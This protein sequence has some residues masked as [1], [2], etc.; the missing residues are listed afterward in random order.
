MRQE[1]T[2][3]PRTSGGPLTESCRP[4]LRT[5]V[6]TPQARG[7]LKDA[8]PV[9]S[10]LPIPRS[11]STEPTSLPLTGTHLSTHCPG[12][13]PPRAVVCMVYFPGDGFSFDSVLAHS[14]MAPILARGQL[15]MTEKIQGDGG[16]GAGARCVCRLLSIIQ[17]GGSERDNA[18]MLS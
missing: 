9:P 12:I 7:P 15:T 2:T 14:Y 1:T 16:G 11:D 4:R 5:R 10:H 8:D 13:Q 17:A 3:I 6:Y 18:T